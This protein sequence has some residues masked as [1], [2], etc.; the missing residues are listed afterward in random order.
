MRK[1]TEDGK[2]GTEDGKEG[3][4]DDLAAGGTG[5]ALCFLRSALFEELAAVEGPHLEPGP[6]GIFQT[7][8][9]CS[10]AFKC[11]YLLHVPRPLTGV[12]QRT[13]EKQ[14]ISEGTPHSLLRLNSFL[15][16]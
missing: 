1:R 12:V 6:S 3:I 10:T 4:E 11:P 2:E 5:C 13:Q 16:M 7:C 9:A 8:K 15:P 14:G